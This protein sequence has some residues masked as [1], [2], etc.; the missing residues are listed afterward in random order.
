L[1]KTA[2]PVADQRVGSDGAAM[3]EID[4]DLQTARD[5]VA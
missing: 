5:D 3:V 2:R 4:E 1:N